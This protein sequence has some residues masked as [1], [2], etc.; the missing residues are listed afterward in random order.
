MVDADDR[1]PK[2]PLDRFKNGFI[3]L[4]LPFFGFSEPIAAP[5]KKCNGRDFTLWDRLEIQG[6]KTL[7]EVIDWI[8]K[9]C[10]VEVSMLSSGVALIYS[11]FMAADKRK[12]RLQMNMKD[13]VE[14]VA[15]KQIPSHA[16]S[17]TLDVMTTDAEGEDVET[18]YVKYTF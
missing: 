18:P 15:R 16:N 17:L 10:N 3:N 5:S 2:V 4:A 13:V 14:H 12:E 7:K 9:E 6:P 11:F 8:Q 1:L